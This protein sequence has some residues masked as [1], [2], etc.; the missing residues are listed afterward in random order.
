MA[1]ESSY[2]R[3]L[4]FDIRC[5]SNFVPSF[6]WCYPMI[7]K[8]VAVAKLPKCDI[9]NCNEDAHYDCPTALGAWGHLCSK[10]FHKF[11][12]EGGSHLYVIQKKEVKHLEGSPRVS[13][14]YESDEWGDIT[15]SVRCPACGQIRN[16]EPDA[17][18]ELNCESCGQTFRCQSMF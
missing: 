18:Y 9:P 12:K 11:G 1:Q 13:L 17:N 10:H 7:A 4:S 14:E 15:A 2:P 5:E 16:V 8:E 3:N 6:Y